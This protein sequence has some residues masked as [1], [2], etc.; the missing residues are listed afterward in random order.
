MEK[1]DDDDGWVLFVGILL[2]L[3]KF[4]K[5]FL[6]F[7]FFVFSEWMSDCVV[8]EICWVILVWFICWCWI[9]VIY[10]WFRIVILFERIL[11][12]FFLDFNSIFM[13]E[14]WSCGWISCCSCVIWMLWVV[15]VVICWGLGG[16]LV[17]GFF[18]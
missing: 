7:V 2:L 13:G 11:V 10:F 5:L 4:L 15:F 14:F 16:L 1:D 3:L 6:L 12:F 18:C 8:G 17:F 9:G